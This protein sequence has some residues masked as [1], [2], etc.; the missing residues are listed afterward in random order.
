MMLVPYFP[1][2]AYVSQIEKKIILFVQPQSCYILNCPVAFITEWLRLGS[3]V[4][5]I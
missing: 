1:K 5:I 4:E 3:T 2:I